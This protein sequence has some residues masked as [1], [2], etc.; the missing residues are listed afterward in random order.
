M[1][2]LVFVESMQALAEL[3]CSSRSLGSSRIRLLAWP[4]EQDVLGIERVQ[5]ACVFK[6]GLEILAN[7]SWV[8]NE[9]V[10]QRCAEQVDICAFVN[11]CGS[12]LSISGAR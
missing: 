5:T 1:R 12:P 10:M 8:P 3:S 9:N 2:L 6:N 7:V 4:A 11:I